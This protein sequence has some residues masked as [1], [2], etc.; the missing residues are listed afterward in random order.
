MQEDKIP[1]NIHT[2]NSDRPA[3]DISIWIIHL[4]MYTLQSDDKDNSPY[5][6]IRTYFVTHHWN[7]LVKTVPMRD[8]NICFLWYKKL[9][10]RYPQYPLLFCT[11]N[12]CKGATGWH[13]SS[14]FSYAVQ[15]LL[16]W[17]RSDD[18]NRSLSSY[19]WNHNLTAKVTD[20]LHIIPLREVTDPAYS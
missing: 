7:R 15:H 10:L 2:E 6:S 18:N 1:H 5:F 11:L 4:R 14:L 13:K 16:S 19:Q 9:P 3:W 8:H 12:K 20:K 17:H